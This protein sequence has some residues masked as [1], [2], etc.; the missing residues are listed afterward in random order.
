MKALSALGALWAILAA[1]VAVT[2]AAQPGAQNLYGVASQSTGIDE[3][4]F[5]TINGIEQWIVI[6]GDDVTNPVLLW[7]HG[8]PGGAGGSTSL[9][10][11]WRGLG[12]KCAACPVGFA[13]GFLEQMF[14]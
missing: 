11:W 1:G 14:R 7:V 9:S 10:G 2:A 3:G 12:T 6:R 13:S 4:S 5:V 8:G